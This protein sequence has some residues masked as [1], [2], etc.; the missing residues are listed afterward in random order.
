MLEVNLAASRQS[1]DMFLVL[2]S[3]HVLI[4]LFLMSKIREFWLLIP[5]NQ[6]FDVEEKLSL[7]SLADLMFPSAGTCL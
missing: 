7:H 2:S 4:F 5:S 1:Y 6:Y 3:L